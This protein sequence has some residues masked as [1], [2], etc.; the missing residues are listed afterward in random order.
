MGVRV[1]YDQTENAAAIYD[2]VT[3]TAFGPV[4]EGTEPPFID[5]GDLANEFLDALHA[6]GLDARTLGHEDLTKR[7]WAFREAARA[8]AD[9]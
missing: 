6:N 8:G 4:V 9:E 1:L 5:A 7:L 3:G 2:S